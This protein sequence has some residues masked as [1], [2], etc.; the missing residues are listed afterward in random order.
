MK[1]LLPEHS[2]ANATEPTIEPTID[3]LT[4]FPVEE[5]FMVYF[6]TGLVYR[7]FGTERNILYRHQVNNNIVQYRLMTKDEI[8]AIT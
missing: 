3:Q 8:K 7:Y 5:Y 2:T 4:L 1:I 6:S